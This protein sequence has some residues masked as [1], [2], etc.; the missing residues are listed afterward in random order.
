MSRP[1]VVL[2]VLIFFGCGNDGSVPR[3]EYAFFVVGHAYGHPITFKPGLH[4]PLVDN[5]DRVTQIVSPDFGILTGDVVAKNDR[6]SWNRA[7]ED[8]KSFGVPVHIAPGN[9]DRGA[10]FN[11]IFDSSWYAFEH[12]RS[13]FVILDTEG[14]QVSNDQIALMS[15]RFDQ[16]DS[17]DNV[18]IFSHELVW[19]APEN[20]YGEIEINY[21]PHYP[22]ETNFYSDVLP[23][24]QQLPLDVYWFAGDVGSRPECTPLSI[25]SEENVTLISNGVGSGTLDNVIV[26]NVNSQGGVSFDVVYLN[27]DDPSGMGGIEDYRW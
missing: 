27:G 13:L 8:I 24:L 20:R 23:V 5:F 2:L 1:I 18:F 15:S 7:L 22:G 3:R 9:H 17:L 4:P 21:R 19:W 14:W 6:E 11:E 10:E 26:V 12:D 25:S 16:I